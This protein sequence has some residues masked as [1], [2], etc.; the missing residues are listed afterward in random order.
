MIV[1]L[2]ESIEEF[3]LARRAD[4]LAASTLSWYASMLNTFLE[5]LGDQPVAQVSTSQLR[6][7]IVALRESD[8]APD[9]IYA[10][11]KALHALFRWAADEYSAP[12]PMRYIAYPKQP[13]AKMPRRAQDADIIKMLGVCGDD[14]Q[15]RRDRAIIGFLTDTGCRA[16]GLVGLTLD[17][18]ELEQRRAFVMEKGERTRP[19]FFSAETADFLQEWLVVRHEGAPDAVFYNL[20]QRKPLTPN[21]LLEILRRLG[22]TAG[23]TGP[24]NPHSFRHR[25][26]VNFMLAGGDSGVLQQML[27]HSDVET[28]IGRYGK[29]GNQELAAAHE[30]RVK[31]LFKKRKLE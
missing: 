6:R 7:Y 10:Y 30:R 29:F 19:V 16:G 23:V 5:Y 25:F 26:G 22:R 2:S 8:Y 9:S 3:L 15:G 28:T 17:R 4:G 31:S 24:V 14:P 27:G 20:R 13:H 18:L 11:I 1:L 21:G 12:N